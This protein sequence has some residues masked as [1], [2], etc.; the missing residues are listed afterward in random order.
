ACR[1][2]QRRFMSLFTVKEIRDVSM[3]NQT[4]VTLRT[5]FDIGRVKSSSA[6]LIQSALFLREELPIRLAK[7]VLELE[8]L[9]YGLSA[10]PSVKKVHNLYVDSFKLL[11]NSP[12]PNTAQGEL[13][14]KEV[15]HG[16]LQRH[17]DVVPL[18]A[19]GI[20]ELKAL[21]FNQASG[22]TFIDECPFLQDFL[23]R[24]YFSRIGIRI[25]IGKSNT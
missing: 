9:P 23:D 14:F 2:A 18:M 7:R 24:F 13:E 21:S 17:R 25:L 10:M 20:K 15:I 22:Y 5:M 1:C 4:D 16:M 11:N 8:N 12:K 3:K 19:M 6:A